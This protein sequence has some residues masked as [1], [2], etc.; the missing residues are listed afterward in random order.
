MRV[1]EGF[2]LCLNKYVQIHRAIAFAVEKNLRK[3]DKKKKNQNKT[4]SY[5]QNAKV[6]SGA[7]CDETQVAAPDWLKYYIL[8]D[9]LHKFHSK[10]QRLVLSEFFEVGM[11]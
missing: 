4:E 9:N 2:L 11:I 8:I 6:K 5:A 1:R 10:L 3:W 7:R